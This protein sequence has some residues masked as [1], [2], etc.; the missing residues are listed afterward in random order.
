MVSN[1]TAIMSV[2]RSAFLWML[3][4]MAKMIVVMVE[5]KLDVQENLLVN[6]VSILS[7]LL[8]IS[9]LLFLSNLVL[10]T[11]SRQISE[12]KCISGD[13]EYKMGE[14]RIS[15][16]GCNTCTCMY[17]GPWE[18][19]TMACNRLGVHQLFLRQHNYLF[20]TFMLPSFVL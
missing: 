17:S 11:I 16:D 18:C 7:S 9:S 14:T 20:A 10:M 15:S 19:T 6:Y 12:T 2:A 4:V 1:L 8:S 5:M 13:K 3:S